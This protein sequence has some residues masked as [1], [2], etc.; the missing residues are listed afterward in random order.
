LVSLS[1][2]IRV[3]ALIGRGAKAPSGSGD[4]K[5][6]RDRSEGTGQR[7]C[8]DEFALAGANQT[9]WTRGWIERVRGRL[10]GEP[11]G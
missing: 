8:P 11:K 1:A 10:D 7:V 5:N 4:L 6:D 3:T 9:A 2:G